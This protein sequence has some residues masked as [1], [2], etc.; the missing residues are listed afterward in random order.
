[1]GDDDGGFFA[2]P[3]IAHR[4]VRDHDSVDAATAWVVTPKFHG[5][6]MSVIMTA[7]GRVKFAR[8]N[9][10][11]QPGESHYGHEAVLSKYDWRSLSSRLCNAVSVDGCTV[12]ADRVT[13]FGELYGGAYPGVRSAH[14]RKPV[15]QHVY[16]SPE[17]HFVAFDVAVVARAP[18]QQPLFLD[19]YDAAQILRTHGIPFVRPRCV[20][21]R[22]AAMRWADEHVSDPVEVSPSLPALPNNVGE[23]WVV[24]PVR[25]ARY[26]NG[27]RVMIKRKSPQFAE[28]T[29]TRLPRGGGP[30]AC[31]KHA[32]AD[33]PLAA[34]INVAR[35][36][37]VLSKQP[38]ADCALENM[39]ALA[40]ALLAD[41][42]ESLRAD[43]AADASAAVAA[44][45][46]ESDGHAD[47]RAAMGLCC[48]C[49]REALAARGPAARRP[50]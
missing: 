20:G 5:T 50:S 13:V 23:G 30:S 36:Q 8:R 21:D 12:R 25:E 4:D 37:S 22:D 2:Y 17:F 11:L 7:E 31:G 28:V 49:V 16:Y 15:Q 44:A 45:A 14:G 9:A 1:M 32:A 38:E 6:N 42:Q 3:S 18:T 46:G 48:K 24:R 41:A 26:R 10:V 40:S 27:T 19:F 33:S 43:R 35:A 34:Y 39:R 47:S 29:H